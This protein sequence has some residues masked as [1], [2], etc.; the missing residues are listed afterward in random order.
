MTPP[1]GQFPSW[2]VPLVA[3]R[4]TLHCPSMNGFHFP[5]SPWNSSNASSHPPVATEGPLPLLHPNLSLP[6]PLLVPSAPEHMCDVALGGPWPLPILGHEYGGRMNS[7]QPHLSTAGFCVFRHLVCLGQQILPLLLGYRGAVVPA[8]PRSS[9][10]I[11]ALLGRQGCLHPPPARP[12]ILLIVP[13]L[14][15]VLFWLTGG[16]TAIFLFFSF[17]NRESK[18]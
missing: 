2:L 6:Q 18:R 13:R 5:A 7:R 15:G 4:T 12:S 1:W 9:P 14:L 8:P 10:S 11:P 3:G 17:L 16:I